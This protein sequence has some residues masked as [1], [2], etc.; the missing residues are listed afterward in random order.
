MSDARHA[1][2]TFSWFE[3]GSR[4]AAAAKAFYTRLFG[5]TAEDQPMPGDMEGHYTMLRLE[6]ED[7]AGLYQLAGPMAELPAHWATYVA[8]SSVDETLG[9]VEALG[10]EVAAPPIDV[11]GVGR[12][13]VLADPTGA[14]IALF[15]AGEHP[16]SGRHGRIPGAFCWSELATDDVAEAG[17]FYSELFGWTMKTDTGDPPYTEF[18]LD[19]TPV[20]GM[21]ALTPHHGDAPPHWLPYVTVADCGRTAA[22]V[23]ELGGSVIVP[24]T[25]VPGVGTFSV[26]FDPGGA[27]LAVIEFAEGAP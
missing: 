26:F 6:G 9:R 19:G 3:C 8:V 24:P 22:K 25:E 27:G 21:M 16:G 7:V 12:I 15:Q 2:G 1:P 10:G 20:A 11:P 18:L 14:T 13:G 23:S 5:W 4:D 17:G